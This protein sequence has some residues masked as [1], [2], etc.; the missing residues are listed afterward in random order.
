MA[1]EEIPRDVRWALPLAAIGIAI[2]AIFWYWDSPTYLAIGM[3]S[4]G[5]SRA[6]G[7]SAA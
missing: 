6:A 4:A 1:D 2:V 7:W 5:R 3:L